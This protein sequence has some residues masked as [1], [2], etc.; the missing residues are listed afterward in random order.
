MDAVRLTV[1]MNQRASRSMS[2]SKYIW[3]AVT[4]D[5]YEFPIAIADSAKELGV[6]YGV[7][8]NTVITLA[9]ENSSGSKTRR[10]FVRVRNEDWRR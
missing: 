4:A 10:K 1:I 3:M 6:R 7:C 8:A 9:R 5:E 2:E